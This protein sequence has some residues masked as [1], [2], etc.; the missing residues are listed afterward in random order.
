[1]EIYKQVGVIEVSNNY[2]SNGILKTLINNGFEI[3]EIPTKD[4]G[5]KYGVL[6]KISINET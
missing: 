2:D 5:F 3:V 4:N 6:V 1:M